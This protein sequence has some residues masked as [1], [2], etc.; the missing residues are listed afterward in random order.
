MAWTFYNSNGEAL[1]QHAESEATKA[2]MEAETAGA[3]FVPP[4]L[5]KNSPGVAKAWC[6]IDTAGT[7]VS[8]DYNI[9]TV[10]D[11]GTGDRGVNMSVYFS[12]GNY[13]VSGMVSDITSGTQRASNFAGGFFRLRVENTSGTLT[14]GRNSIV[15]HGDQ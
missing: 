13:T 6:R 2:E 12:S 14:D 10:D 11:D 7:L 1:V 5:V 9:A 3:K 15:C 8:P 4:D